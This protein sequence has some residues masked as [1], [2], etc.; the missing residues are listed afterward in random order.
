MLFRGLIRHCPRC[1]GGHLFRRWFTM[2]DHCPRCG[3]RFEREEGFFLGA[4][5]VNAG[6]VLIAM[7]A[8]IGIG[9]AVSLPDPEP[10]KLSMIVLAFAIGVPIG[11]YPFSKT[12]WSAID[13][14]MHPLDPEEVDAAAVRTGSAP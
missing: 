12:L 5:V 13:L 3:L 1:G 14:W 6:A 7:A 8:A 11:F 9:V 4:I 10:V 2:V